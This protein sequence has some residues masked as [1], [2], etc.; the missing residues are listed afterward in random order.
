MKWKFWEKGVDTPV[1]SKTWWR[2]DAVCYAC[3]R[4]DI[5]ETRQTTL[6]EFIDIGTG[7]QTKL[8]AFE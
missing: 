6:D 8:G 7:K 1:R 2:L 3:G 4:Q 5:L